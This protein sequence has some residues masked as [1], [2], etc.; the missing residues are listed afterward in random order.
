MAMIAGVG[1]HLALH[2]DW[3]VCMTRRMLTV[4]RPI[5]EEPAAYPIE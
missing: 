3:M 1:A 2:W 4:K 5:K